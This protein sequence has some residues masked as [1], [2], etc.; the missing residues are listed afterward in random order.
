MVEQGTVNPLVPGSSPGRGAKKLDTN[1]NFEVER[2][3]SPS[4]AN[5]GGEQENPS[6]RGQKFPP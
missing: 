4:P 1:S 5:G 6:V 3:R 2:V